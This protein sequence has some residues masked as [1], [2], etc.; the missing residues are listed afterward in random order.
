MVS[1][2]GL[3]MGRQSLAQYW[4]IITPPA[5]KNDTNVVFLVGNTCYK[6]ITVRTLMSGIEVRTEEE[7]KNYLSRDP[8][9]LKQENKM[10][11]EEVEQREKEIEAEQ[12]AYAED[13]NC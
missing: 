5:I 6:V 7:L 10:Y 8:G 2:Q 3:S 9:E 1:G 13:V 11:Y 4:N 12:N